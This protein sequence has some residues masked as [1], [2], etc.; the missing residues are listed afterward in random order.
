MNFQW[1]SCSFLHIKS[2]QDFHGFVFL[3]NEKTKYIGITN[4]NGYIFQ[5]NEIFE[6]KCF[7][8]NEI[9]SVSSSHWQEI[10]LPEQIQSILFKT[11]N[12]RKFN[13]FLCIE[14]DKSE[15]EKK[16]EIKEW[17]KNSLSQWCHQTCNYHYS[18]CIVGKNVLQQISIIASIHSLFSHQNEIIGWKTFPHSPRNSNG[19]IVTN[20]QNQIIGLIVLTDMNENTTI[21]LQINHFLKLINQLQTFTSVEI[22]LY[23]ITCGSKKGT[24]C[25]IDTHFNGTYLITSA[26]TFTQRETS[27]LIEVKINSMSFEMSGVVVFYSQCLD[28]VVIFI[29][30]CLPTLQLSSTIPLSHSFHSF[31]GYPMNKESEKQIQ[32]TNIL[33]LSGEMISIVKRKENPLIYCSYLSVSEGMSGGIMLNEGKCIGMIQRSDNDC[34][35]CL[36]SIVIN[37]VMDLLKQQKTEEEI[38]IELMDFG[39]V[40]EGLFSCD[41]YYHYN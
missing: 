26:H 12:E 24:C 17:N 27:F 30:L 40:Y 7:D 16:R 37:E 6:M 13:T 22:P 1:K 10:I 15:I 2:Q 39:I 5:P 14:F 28:L 21:I 35:Y 4:T 8:N 11:E 41:D 23:R 31:V 20:E 29:P 25:S 9:I 32:S 33:Q 19:C 3:N 34:T 36:S 38:Q 18:D